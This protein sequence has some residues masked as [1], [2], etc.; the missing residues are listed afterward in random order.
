MNIL[1]KFQA[2]SSLSV[3]RWRIQD[4]F[5]NKFIIV[6]PIQFKNFFRISGNDFVKPETLSKLVGFCD[7]V[8]VSFTYLYLQKAIEG[9]LFRF[10]SLNSSNVSTV[11]SSSSWSISQVPKLT[12]SNKLSKTLLVT[13]QL[14]SSI[15]TLVLNKWSIQEFLLSITFKITYEEYKPLSQRNQNGNIE[16]GFDSQ[17]LFSLKKSDNSLIYGSQKAK[18]LKSKTS[19]VWTR[20]QLRPEPPKLVFCKYCPEEQDYT[21]STTSNML[22][23]TRSHHKNELKKKDKVEVE[24]Q[25]AQ[26]QTEEKLVQET[27]LLSQQMSKSKSRETNNLILLQI[28]KNSLPLNM[29]EQEGFTQLINNFQS[30]DVAIQDNIEKILV[31]YNLIEDQ[32]ISQEENEECN[33]IFFTADGF[34]SNKLAIKLQQ[35][36]LIVCFIHT[37]NNTLKDMLNISTCS[38]ILN[39]DARLAYMKQYPKDDQCQYILLNMLSPSELVKAQ[40]INLPCHQYFLKFFNQRQDFNE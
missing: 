14:L 26:F 21:I 36:K 18:K 16:K 33:P 13:K 5:G 17:Y 39:K 1:P 24:I 25:N 28:I 9:T 23:H 6:N 40:E 12:H 7:H 32:M 15:S 22:L 38:T 19:E 30:T 11:S 34:S 29:I 4:K 27:C 10:L 3:G 20:W 35:Q 31:E 2:L 37:C 8:F